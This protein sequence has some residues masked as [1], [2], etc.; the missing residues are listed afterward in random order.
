MTEVRQGPTPRVCFREVSALTRCDCTSVIENA[1][2]LSISFRK[3]HYYYYYYYYL[4]FSNM[5]VLNN[6]AYSNIT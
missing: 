4:C 6:S 2:L 3:I 1:Q 5:T